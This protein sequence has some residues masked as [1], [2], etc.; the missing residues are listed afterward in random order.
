MLYL[1]LFPV[2]AGRFMPVYLGAAE[3]SMRRNADL[4]D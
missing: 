4:T 1:Q 2:D 3:K